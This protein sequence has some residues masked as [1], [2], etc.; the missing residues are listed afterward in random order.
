MIA[1]FVPSLSDVLSFQCA[2]I[3]NGSDDTF[4]YCFLASSRCSLICPIFLRGADKLAVATYILGDDIEFRRCFVDRVNGP[5]CPMRRRGHENAFHRQVAMYETKGRLS[6]TARVNRQ[7]SPQHRSWRENSVSYEPDGRPVPFW[8]AT[9]PFMALAARICAVGAPGDTTII[10]LS[11]HAPI[12]GWFSLVIPSALSISALASEIFLCRSPLRA[13]TAS[14]IVSIDVLGEMK[15]TSLPPPSVHRQRS[16]PGSGL[17]ALAWWRG[18]RCA[19]S[20]AYARY[21]RCR[22]YL[23]AICLEGGLCA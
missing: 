1:N 14:W 10:E 18:S 8:S 19:P 3:R 7:R 12:A 17:S 15:A 21:R 16:S 13:L 6:T 22:L 4:S 5:R 2:G 23:P 20:P 11:A 9:Y